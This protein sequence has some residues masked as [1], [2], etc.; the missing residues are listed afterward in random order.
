VFDRLSQLVDKSLVQP[1]PAGAETRYRLLETIRQYCLLKLAESGAEAEFRD[2]HLDYFVAWATEVEPLVAG[3]DAFDWAGR[4]ILEHDNMRAA[5]AWALTRPDKARQSLQLASLSGIFWAA[6]GYHSESRARLAAALS[7]PGSDNREC[8]PARAR[9]LCWAGTLAF[10]QSDYAASRAH[11]QASLELYQALGQAGR[12]GLADA[13]EGLAEVDTEVGDYLAAAQRYQAALTIDREL[14]KA[15]AVARDLTMLAWL[16]MRAGA[17][18]EAAARFDEALAHCR[19]LGDPSQIAEALAGRGELAVRQ[20][21]YLLA[22]TLLAES[23]EVRRKLGEVMGLAAALGSLGWAA[24]RQRDFNRM[25]DLLGESLGLRRDGGDMGGT[26]WCLEK[27]A[28][29]AMLIGQ[30]APAAGRHAEFLRA[31][32]LFGAAAALRHRLH[33]AMDEADQPEFERQLEALAADLGEQ[34]FSATWA[35]GSGLSLEQAIALALAEP[36]SAASGQ[37]GAAEA[38]GLETFGGL[39]ARE[40]QV[41]G[42]IAHGQS[43]RKIAEALVVS[44]KTV[45]TYVTRILGKLGF[46]SRVQIATWAVEKGLALPKKD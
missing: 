46:D 17:D 3:P 29:A 22:E 8:A 2:R 19:L 42:L 5:F 43:N 44:V 10:L 11:Y 1:D 38:P 28:E 4:I 26:A 36:V 35:E 32:R 15:S 34:V 13:L 16:A 20:G 45:E 6:Q 41:A 23:V 27:L 25:R 39:T 30:S 31:A 37:P 24:L 7:Q 33:A 14:G 40:R 12:S 18:D 21:H 9:A